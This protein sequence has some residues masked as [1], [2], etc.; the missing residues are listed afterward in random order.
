MTQSH[1]SKT[2]LNQCWSEPSDLWVILNPE[3]NLWT[4]QIDP[5]LNL[6]LRRTYVRAESKAKV[7]L[8]AP[9]LVASP[10]GH[11][12]PRVLLMEDQDERGWLS[13]VLKIASGLKV[14]SV[15]VFPPKAWSAPS[16]SRPGATD[17]MEIR[18][19]E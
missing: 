16:A 14:N 13:A 9:V 8:T 5:S 2:S 6:L 11:P 17:G 7:E 3:Q 1:L 18:W 4:E 12:A 15:T 19:V 10:P